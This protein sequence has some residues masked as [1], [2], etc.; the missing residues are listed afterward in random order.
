MELWLGTWGKGESIQGQEILNRPEHFSSP[1]L[2]GL[3]RV[4]LINCE[5]WVVVLNFM[6]A[7]V[8]A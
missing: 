2:T 5:G 8:D 6:M 7:L 4:L 1:L 3:C